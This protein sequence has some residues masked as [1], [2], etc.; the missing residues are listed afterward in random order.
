LRF[1]VDPARDEF[2][3]VRPDAEAWGR[4][5]AATG[6]SVESLENYRGLA[7]IRGPGANRV[8]DVTVN[9]WQLP[10]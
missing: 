5:A 10:G 9:V 2:L 7:W 4:L 8:V 3:E 6:G 1:E